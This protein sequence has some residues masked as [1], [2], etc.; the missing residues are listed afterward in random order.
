MDEPRTRQDAPEVDQRRTDV[1][2]SRRID[3]AADTTWGHD[4]TGPA[5][6]PEGGVPPE[7]GTEVAQQ[8]DAN[9]LEDESC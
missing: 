2:S 3:V 1:G 5:R 4:D 8:L 6:G 9:A 7:N